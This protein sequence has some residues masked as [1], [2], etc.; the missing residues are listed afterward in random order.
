MLKSNIE[1][2]CGMEMM[3]MI[4]N[5]IVGLVLE[6]EK[7]EVWSNSISNSEYMYL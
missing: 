3:T 6:Q 5:R 2:D 1:K 7:E 4:S